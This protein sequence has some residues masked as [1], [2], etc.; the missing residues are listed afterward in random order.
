[1]KRYYVS[2]VLFGFIII[3][4]MVLA[5]TGV[6]DELIGMSL[7]LSIA[8]I[9]NLVV[10]RV[11]FKNDVKAISILM[12]IFAL[13]GLVLLA[14]NIYSMVSQKVENDY[15]FQI[16]VKVDTSVKT[17]M[18]VYDGVEYYKY[19]LSEVNVEM[20]DGEKTLEE[21]LEA[22]YVTLDD[23][24][25]MAIANTD[26]VGYEIYYDG[27]T[28]EYENDAYSIVVCE[29]DNVVFAPFNYVY[30]EDLCKN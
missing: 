18:F 30:T 5:L 7:A 9:F 12:V 22:N 14:I 29:N 2:I 19:N 13:L 4:M 21:A 25:S 26:T 27:G 11:A 24:L 28:S 15:K 16:T 3:L 20:K 23:I 17:K 6:I 1:M 10:A 8:I